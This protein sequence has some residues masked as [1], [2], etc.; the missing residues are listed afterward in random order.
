MSLAP[1]PAA[2]IE[3]RRL[4]IPRGDT[5]PNNDRFPAVLARNALGGVQDD[6]EVRRLMEAN[7]WGGTWTWRVFDYHHFHPDCFEALA[8][9]RGSARLMLGGP[10][11]EAVE[12]AAGD[13]AILPPGFGHRQLSSSTDFAICGAYPHG[14]EDYSILRAEDGFDAATLSRIADMPVPSIDPVWGGRGPL[15]EAL[16]G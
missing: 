2:T 12:V 5:I 13:V 14:Q 15:L 11:G 7:G 1:A 8:V 16:V 10:Q 6:A 3:I 4:A 9:A